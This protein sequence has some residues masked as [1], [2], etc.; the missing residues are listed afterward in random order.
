ML[1]VGWF[2]FFVFFFEEQLQCIGMFVQGNV[3]E[4]IFVEFY[5]GGMGY[6]FDDVL[7]VFYYFLYNWSDVWEC[8]VCCCVFFWYI[9]GGGYFVDQCV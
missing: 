4:V 6:W 9:E 5:F 2:S 1:L 8:K 7:I 3:D